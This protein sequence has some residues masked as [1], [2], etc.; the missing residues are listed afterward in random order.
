MFKENP[1]RNKG[2]EYLKSRTGTRTPVTR[3]GLVDCD[4]HGAPGLLKNKTQD[5]GF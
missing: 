1:R 4:K 2:R 3:A 5:L